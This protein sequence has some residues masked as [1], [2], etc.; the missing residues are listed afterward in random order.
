MDVFW[1]ADAASSLP[2]VSSTE[3]KLADMKEHE[4]IEKLAAARRKAKALADE[5]SSKREHKY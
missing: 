3:V 5:R 1:A 4:C 2:S